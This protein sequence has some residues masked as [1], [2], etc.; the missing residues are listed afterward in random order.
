MVAEVDFQNVSIEDEMRKSY[1][2]YSMSVIV[3]RALPDIRDGLKPV[4][5]RVLFAGYQYCRGRGC[6]VSFRGDRSR[7]GASC[8]PKKVKSIHINLYH[9][10]QK[11]SVFS[12]NL[13]LTFLPAEILHH[14]DSF[15][16]QHRNHR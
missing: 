11:I 1:L 14:E 2:E 4:H 13:F 12:G 15:A 5:R 16:L 8:A 10:S 6:S 7:S 3:G 9:L